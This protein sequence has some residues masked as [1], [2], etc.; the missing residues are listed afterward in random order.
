[1]QGLLVV[2]HGDMVQERTLLLVLGLLLVVLMQLLLPLLRHPEVY[3]KIGC[4]VM[5]VL[6]L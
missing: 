1:M 5:T 6:L 2:L 4:L 3:I